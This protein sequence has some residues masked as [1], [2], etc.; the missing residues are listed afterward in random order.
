MHIVNKAVAGTSPPSYTAATVR[1]GT[2]AVI[3]AATFDAPIGG[4]PSIAFIAPNKRLMF[5]TE[6]FDGARATQ[7]P[8]EQIDSFVLSTNGTLRPAPGSP[9]TLPPDTSG[10][11]P[12]PQPL[13]L[14][15]VA[16]PTAKVLYVGFFSR[17]QIGVYTY[18]ATTGELTFVRAVPNSGTGNGWFLINKRATRLYSVNSGSATI[19]VFDIADPLKPV[20]LKALELK[21]AMIGPPF[22]D[23]MGVTQTV[24]SAPFQFAFDPDQTHL[25]VVS[26]RVTTNAS[27]PTGNFLHTLDI[28]ADGTLTE[29]VDPIDLRTLSVPPRARPQGVVVVTP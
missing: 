12:S 11:T 25:Y 27:D 2:L 16:H 21:N 4:S 1:E 28:A 8:V 29:P 7:A 19:S 15:L 22:V 6:F 10:M 14:N 5:G 20:E 13:A 18:N 3:P 23:A 26:Q 9:Y 24:T 17:S